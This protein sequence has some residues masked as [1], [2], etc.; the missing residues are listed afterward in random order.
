M[1]LDEMFMESK[2]SEFNM[3]KLNKKLRLN[4]RHLNC[5]W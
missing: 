3:C 4:M 1:I 5:P 2:T